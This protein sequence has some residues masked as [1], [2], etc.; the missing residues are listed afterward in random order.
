MVSCQTMS[1]LPSPLKLPF[2]TIDRWRVLSQDR[3]LRDLPVG[4]QPHEARS[5]DRPDR[6][7]IFLADADCAVSV[8]FI[9]RSNVGGAPRRRTVHWD[10]ACPLW[11]TIASIL[12][13]VENWLQIF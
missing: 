5:R 8:P 4:H 6:R 9:N 13:W 11:R 2:S 1:L 7:G 3:R 10:R 12:E